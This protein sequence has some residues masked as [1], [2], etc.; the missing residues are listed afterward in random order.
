MHLKQIVRST[1]DHDDC[2]DD[3]CGDD[4]NDVDDDDNDGWGFI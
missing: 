2:D 3:G 4:E 1:G